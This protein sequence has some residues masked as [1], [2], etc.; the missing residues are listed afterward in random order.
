V[1]V[2]GVEGVVSFKAAKKVPS[3]ALLDV[4]GTAVVVN[5]K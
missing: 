4:S 1:S 3:L 2:M 5:A